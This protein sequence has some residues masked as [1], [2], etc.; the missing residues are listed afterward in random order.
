MLTVG[1]SKSLTIKYG[2][3]L[4]KYADTYHIQAQALQD[5]PSKFL[6]YV[7]KMAGKL[8]DANPNLF[9]DVQL[10]THRSAAPGLTLEQTFE[11][12]WNNCK[13]YVDGVTVFFGNDSTDELK[14]FVQ[15]FDAH[16]R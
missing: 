12:D 1:T 15:W 10:S 4:A 7:K 3:Q 8:R 13:P 14:T 6:S 5:E 16:G 11:E 2:P 9:I